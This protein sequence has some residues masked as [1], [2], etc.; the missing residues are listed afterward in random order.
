LFSVGW[1]ESTLSV[2]IWNN[3]TAELRMAVTNVAMLH[4]IPLIAGLESMLVLI[5]SLMLLA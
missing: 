3:F 5:L 4:A 1:G 2:G